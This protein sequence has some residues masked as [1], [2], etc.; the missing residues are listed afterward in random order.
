MIEKETEDRIY[1]YFY[2]INLISKLASKNT[3]ISIFFQPQMLPDN[4]NRLSD[5]DQRIFNDFFETTWNIDCCT[6]VYREI[7]VPW[8]VAEASIVSSAP[9]R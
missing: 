7:F 2:N 6:E 4:I 9:P 3:Y 5:N 8:P 1:R